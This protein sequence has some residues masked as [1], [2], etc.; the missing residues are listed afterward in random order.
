MNIPKLIAVG[1]IGFACSHFHSNAAVV[2]VSSP[3]GATEITEIIIRLIWQSQSP[4][5]MSGVRIARARMSFRVMGIKSI[6]VSI[7]DMPSLPA[8]SA[9]WI[10]LDALS[11]R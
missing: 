4:N 11:A 1:A 7:A 2:K 9:K 5:S 3:D 8:R 6:S 10:R